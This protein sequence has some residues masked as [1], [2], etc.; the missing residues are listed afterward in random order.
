MHRFTLRQLEYLV[1]AV[2]TGSI[3]NAAAALNVSQPTIS[4]AL[5]KIEAQL[6]VQLLI[7]HT[8]QGVSPTPLG[9]DTVIAARA[10]LAQASALQ[11]DAMRAGEAVTG[12]LRLGSFLTLSPLILPGLIRTLQAEAP[13]IELQI[14]E[15]SQDV[16]VAELLAGQLDLA[17]LYDLDLPQE[18][19]RLNLSKTPP[20]VALPEAHPLTQKRQVHLE[21]LVEE[22]MILLDVSPSRDYFLGLFE[23]RQ[24][25][26]RI[27]HSSPSL[28]LV[29]GMVGCGLGYA[30]LAT[31]PLGDRTYSGEKIVVRALK[32]RPRPSRI[33]LAQNAALRPT[34]LSEKFLGVAKSHFAKSL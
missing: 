19:E 6:G 22:P 1:A 31:R 34:R 29:R 7:R 11:T 18:L 4:V 32:G 12:T 27:A 2:E 25:T 20:Y 10:L 16:L 5:S 28:E 23:D 17:L 8:S 14:R 21:D 24:L 26:P 13:G 3:A 9:A 30:L 33:V 15:A